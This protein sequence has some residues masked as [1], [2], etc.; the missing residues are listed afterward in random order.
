MHTSMAQSPIGARPPARAPQPK[1]TLLTPL[2][3][4]DDLATFLPRYALAP[5]DAVALLAG[6]AVRAGD[7]VL[8]LYGAR[9]MS[10]TA[11]RELAPFLDP[12]QTQHAPPDAWVIARGMRIG[13]DRTAMW[14]QAIADPRSALWHMMYAAEMVRRGGQD[15]I[16]WA[17]SI[18]VPPRDA[19]NDLLRDRDAYAVQLWG[20]ANPYLKPASFFAASARLARGS[21]VP[22]PHDV[23]LCISGD[24]D[25]PELTLAHGAAE[26]LGSLQMLVVL[27]DTEIE[28]D[29]RMSQWLVSAAGVMPAPPSPL[30]TFAEL[31]ASGPVLL[32]RRRGIAHDDTTAP[33]ALMSPALCSAGLCMR[34][35][36]SSVRRMNLRLDCVQPG[37]SGRM[38]T[39]YLRVRPV[40]AQPPIAD[41]SV[42]QLVQPA[43][44]VGTLRRDS[45]PTRLL[46]DVRVEFTLDSGTARLRTAASS[47]TPNLTGA[48]VALFLEQAAG[49]PRAAGG[50]VA[51]SPFPPEPTAPLP[52]ALLTADTKY[53]RFQMEAGPP[54]TVPSSMTRGGSHY[55][56]PD[57]MRGRM[58]DDVMPAWFALSLSLLHPDAALMRRECAAGLRV[59]D[60]AQ[61]LR[62]GGIMH[63]HVRLYTDWRATAGAPLYTQGPIHLIFQLVHHDDGEPRTLAYVGSHTEDDLRDRRIAPSSWHWAV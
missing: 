58:R 40:Y 28:D 35:Y 7:E 63:V 23:C 14:A 26:L 49:I 36:A 20:D 54:A 44:M 15:R 62:R 57:A 8:A 27:V 19:L 51:S 6:A 32:V 3:S 60:P 17:R 37:V 11:L 21:D 18:S 13:A 53:M 33:G 5:P 39:D 24:H 31:M 38:A 2:S 56:V 61:V 50:V 46:A 30:R 42:D 55:V 48:P 43:A 29:L 52:F 45:A 34:V 9:E 59:M 1:A 12:V 41:L 25:A 16:H 22:S 47:I 4:S 10:T